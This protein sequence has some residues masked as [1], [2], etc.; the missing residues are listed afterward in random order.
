MSCLRGPTVRAWWYSPATGTAQL[1]GT[2]PKG[3]RSFF[4]P[5]ETDWVLVLDDDALGF[6]PPGT[7]QSSA[8]VLETSSSVPRMALERIEPNPGSGSTRIC[9]HLA[10]AG[11]VQATVL[12]VDGRRIRGIS[13]GRLPGGSHVLHWDGRD[14]YGRVAGA[15]TYLVRLETPEGRAFGKLVRVH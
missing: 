9:Y 10:E 11:E 1:N 15:G 2:Y 12:T 8:A 3:T 14:D 13:A 4:S 5:S 7:P 6:P